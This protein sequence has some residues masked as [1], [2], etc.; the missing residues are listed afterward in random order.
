MPEAER[1]RGKR[2][3]ARLQWLRGA[4]A[5]AETR[6]ETARRTKFSG[7]PRAKKTK[8][9]KVP[10]AFC[11]DFFFMIFCDFKP[12]QSF[13]AFWLEIVGLCLCLTSKILKIAFL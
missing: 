1:R 9:G 12:Y 8:E 7:P 10:A 2:A 11:V 13:I 6:A 3:S 4:E 5:K